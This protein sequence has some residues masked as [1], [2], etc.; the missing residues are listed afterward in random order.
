MLYQLSYS[1]T[2][3]RE[4]TLASLRHWVPG[5]AAE[6][7]GRSSMPKRALGKDLTEA[8][9]LR[10]GG[11][12]RLERAITVDGRQRW[13]YPISTAPASRQRGAGHEIFSTWQLCSR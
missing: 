13:V 7:Y 11:P 6:S 12:S 5:A 9:I 10:R 3:A 8:R 2:V 4:L 1:R